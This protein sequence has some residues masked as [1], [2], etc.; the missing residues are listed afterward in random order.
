MITLQEQALVRQSWAEVAKLGPAAAAHFYDRLFETNPSL[1]RL[2]DGTDMQQQH[3]RLLDALGF[4]IGRMDRL[5]EVVP[6]LENLGRR[7]CCYGV[8]AEH[9]AA[10]GAALLWTLERA[11]GADWNAD[12]CAAWSSAYG[13]VAGTMCGAAGERDRPTARP[14]AAAVEAG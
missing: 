4:V 6:V 2:F 11:H 13:L 14:T 1:V 7:H 8:E 3:A 5:E 12:L 9:Y 10:V